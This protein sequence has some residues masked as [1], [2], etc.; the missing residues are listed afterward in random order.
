MLLRM[1]ADPTRM[2]IL[3]RLRAEECDVATLAHVLDVGR[4]AVSQH[5]AKLRL[6]GLV[7]V[8]KDGRR[9]L[10]R[11]RGVHV[12]SLLEAAF[13]AADNRVN[14]LPDHPTP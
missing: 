6:A 14:N 2:R 1:L 13:G 9:S 5:L 8:R 10:Y 12:A 7:G 11:T 3:W 4:P